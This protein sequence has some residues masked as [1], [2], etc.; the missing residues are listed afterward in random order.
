MNPKVSNDLN[1]SQDQEEYQEEY[2][3]ELL[4]DDHDDIAEYGFE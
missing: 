3:E 2:I 4:G 1:D